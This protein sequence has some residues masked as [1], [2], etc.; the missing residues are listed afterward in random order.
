[1]KDSSTSYRV[2][3]WFGTFLM[4][5][6]F[7]LSGIGMGTEAFTRV[8]PF[9]PYNAIVAPHAHNMFLQLL[10]ETGIVGI[11]VF[12]IILIAFFKELSQIHKDGGRKSPVSVMTVAIASAVAGFLLQ[13]IF[14]NCF[15][16]YR[17]F[18]IFWLVLAVGVAALSAQREH[19][20]SEEEAL[21]ND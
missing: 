13:G 20:T 15:Y 6:D 7:W 11:M 18:M 16:N 1:M 5:K 8:Y 10:V 4:L 3:I 14:D 9:Y 2:Y 21:K 12:V 19:I 17:V